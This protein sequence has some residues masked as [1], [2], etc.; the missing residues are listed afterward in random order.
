MTNETK[1]RESGSGSVLLP[2]EVQPP[3]TQP[4]STVGLPKST[5][6]QQRYLE[7]IRVSTQSYDRTVVIGGRRNVRA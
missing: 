1:N 5:V 6:D 7:E 3:V 2:H 4:V